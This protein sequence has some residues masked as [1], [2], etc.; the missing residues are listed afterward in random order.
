MRLQGR[1]LGWSVMA[2]VTVTAAGLAAAPY[3]LLD[4][5][6]SRVQLDPSFTL[7][8]PLLLV[9]IFASFIALVIGW[10]QFIPGLRKKYPRLHRRIGIVYMGGI[11]VG[12]ITGFVVGLHTAS[13]IRQTAFWAL[14]VLWLVTGWKGYR[15]VRSKRIESH[16][17]WM[18]RNYAVTLVAASARIITPILLLIYVAG[19][20][21][22]NG[23]LDALGHVLEVN[24]WTGLVLNLIV[25][26]WVLMRRRGK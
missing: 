23:I 26:E 3:F 8:F 16:G 22:S 11:A 12:G 14:A 21:G 19:H 1:Q 2:L 17:Q 25:V 24:I 15:A 10:V 5:A 20:P 13:F 4:P 7:H 18:M 9:H 6:N